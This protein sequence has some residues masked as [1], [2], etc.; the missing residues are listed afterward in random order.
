MAWQSPS[1]VQLTPFSLGSS[2]HFPCVWSGV[3]IMFVV[4]KKAPLSWKIDRKCFEKAN[5]LI[6]KVKTKQ[7]WICGNQ[8]KPLLYIL[9][10]KYNNT[11]HCL[12]K[13]VVPENIHTH[14]TGG[15]L[16]F[17]RGGGV[18]RTGIPRTWGVIR[19]EFR[20]HGDGGSRDFLPVWCS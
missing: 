1:L 5:D 9:E 4:T 13:W 10:Q 16:E 8:L 17:P 6:Q 14:T 15:I 12:I 11:G 19:L 20:R 2:G 18:T 3:I 7:L